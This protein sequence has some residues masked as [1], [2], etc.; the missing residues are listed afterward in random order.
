MNANNN[1]FEMI[2]AIKNESYDSYGMFNRRMFTEALKKQVKGVE[3]LELVHLVQDYRTAREFFETETAFFK[4]N[5]N[6]G[7][8]VVDINFE[9]E[10]VTAWKEANKNVTRVVTSGRCKR[11][12]EV[13]D[14]GI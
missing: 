2:K 12:I 3:K 8:H 1:I 10:L 6:N 7:G 5:T 11:V 14:F 9:E 4:Y 13:N